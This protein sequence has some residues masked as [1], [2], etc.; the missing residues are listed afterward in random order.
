MGPFN[1]YEMSQEW[2]AGV[3]G[4]RYGQFCYELLRKF[5]WGEGVIALLLCNR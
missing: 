3:A 5:S 2:V 4:V 1:N